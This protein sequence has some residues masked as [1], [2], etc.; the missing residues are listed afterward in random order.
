MQVTLAA[1]R[2]AALLDNFSI[3]GPQVRRRK[4]VIG[5]SRWPAWFAA[6]YGAGFACGAVVGIAPRL[7]WPAVVLTWVAFAAI[8]CASLISQRF[9]LHAI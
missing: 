6:G 2:R 9:D 8:A 5:A 4:R 3:S 7:T 1:L